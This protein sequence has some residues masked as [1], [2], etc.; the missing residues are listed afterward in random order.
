MRAGG[1]GRR[2]ATNPRLPLSRQTDLLVAAGETGAAISVKKS[3]FL[4]PWDMKNVIAKIA[5]TGNQ[6]V[7]VCERGA[8]FGYNTL[9]SDM[10]ASRS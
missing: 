9:V 1:R 6:S 5:A 8:R 2:R 4:A 7:L 10:P 3:Q